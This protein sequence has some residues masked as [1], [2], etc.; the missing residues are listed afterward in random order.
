MVSCTL[1]KKQLLSLLQDLPVACMLTLQLSRRSTV[2]AQA[3]YEKSV[4]SKTS[5]TNARLEGAASAAGLLNQCR[6]LHSCNS[7]LSA[8]YVA[9]GRATAEITTFSDVIVVYKFLGDL[10]FYVTGAQDENE[11]VLYQVLQGFYES[12]S[13]LLRCAGPARRSADCCLPP[14]ACCLFG[15]QP[16]LPTRERACFAADLAHT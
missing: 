12:I 2:T 8:K 14:A 10:M 5:R 15:R 6:Y 1:Y 4:F 16:S 7:G 13:L 3:N 11:L 9:P